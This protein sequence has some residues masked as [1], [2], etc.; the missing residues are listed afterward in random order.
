MAKELWQAINDVP[1]L[2]A[3]TAGGKQAQFYNRLGSPMG[4]YT[5]SLEQNLYLLEQINKGNFGI[6]PTNQAPATPQSPQQ[7]SG[8][9]NQVQAQDIQDA[10]DPNKLFDSPE[11]A[12]A[13]AAS[14]AALSKITTMPNAPTAP[15][16]EQTFSDLRNEYNVAGLENDLNTLTSEKARLEAEL[17]LR[18]NN[19]RN[20]RVGL[21][22]I[23]G[24]VDE[25]TRQTQEEMDF[26]NRQ[27]Q[28]VSDQVKT[29]YN[30]IST[31][32]QLKTAD[33]NN[34]MTVYNTDLNKNLKMYE[35][36][37]DNYRD[38]R[39]FTERT[40]KRQE[41]TAR[42]NLQIYIN[43]AAEGALDM[44]SVDENTK[45]QI[46]K[47]EAQSGLPVGFMSKIQVPENK[48][49]M[50]ITTRIDPSGRKVADILMMGKNGQGMEVVQRDLGIDQAYID[51]R[52]AKAAA[53]SAS[54]LN[55]QAALVNAQNKSQSEKMAAAQDLTKAFNSDIDKAK[56]SLRDNGSW[57]EVW[58]T[59]KA[60]YPQ[61]SNQDLDYALGVPKDWIAS[62]KPGWEWWN[63]YGS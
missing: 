1:G 2:D 32:T 50:S 27:I 7:V 45:L 56:Q 21:G 62:G 5:G 43:L 22:V 15:N 20:Q 47:L 17:R 41:D 8:Y 13:K 51:D 23:A 25:V 35:M 4:A 40:V 28:T 38:L 29:A 30:L 42:A 3:P 63:Q 14:D 52:N 49:V 9:L 58:N 39:D 36:M 24:Q 11:L 19:I 26:V 33:F 55:A 10:N 59:L 61:V 60:R 16:L 53:A 18:T 48:R 6:Q 46:A 44:N 57:G 31:I 12:N 54:Y 37:S 34:A